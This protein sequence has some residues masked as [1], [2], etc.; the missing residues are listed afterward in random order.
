MMMTSISS[1]IPSSRTNRRFEKE[2]KLHYNTNF[3]LEVR[4]K[5]FFETR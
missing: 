3:F 1:E 4:E 2:T 5:K